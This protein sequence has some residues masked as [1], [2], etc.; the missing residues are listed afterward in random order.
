MTCL[1]PNTKEYL[2]LKNMCKSSFKRDSEWYSV[3]FNIIQQLKVLYLNGRNKELY[4]K[5]IGIAFNCM[6]RHDSS[7]LLK[8]Y[9]N[10]RPLL[11]ILMSSEFKN[12]SGFSNSSLNELQTI[13]L[14]F[15]VFYIQMPLKER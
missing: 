13:Y 12:K 1:K 8:D 6:V 5:M 15:I 3:M 4:M 11:P 2:D 10:I 9:M 14:H 7:D